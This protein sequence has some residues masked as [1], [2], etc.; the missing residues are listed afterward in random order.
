[1]QIVSDDPS[2]FVG[3]SVVHAG[4]QSLTIRALRRQGQRTI[5]S[6]EE[7]S[8][9]NAAEALRGS[10]L[11]VPVDAARALDEA[12]YWDHDLVGCTVVTTDGEEVGVVTDVLHQPANEVLVVSGEILIPF[13]ASVVTR[14]EPRAKIT[15]S[16]LPGLIGDDESPRR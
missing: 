4:H 12:E 3:G 15:I 2:R 10:E 9:R 5:V 16:P 6:F 14:V 13:V 11:V 7:I 1:M 8:D